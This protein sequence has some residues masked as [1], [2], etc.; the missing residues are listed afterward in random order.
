MIDKPS[1]VGRPAPVAAWATSAALASALIT[2]VLWGASIK[3]GVDD[4]QNL[5]INANITAVKVLETNVSMMSR[6]LER[7]EANLDKLIGRIP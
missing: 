4:S 2:S 3:L 5:A 6:S 1:G 7:I